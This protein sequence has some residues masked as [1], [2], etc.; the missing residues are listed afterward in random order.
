[1]VWSIFPYEN[2]FVTTTIEK[3]NGVPCLKFIPKNH[4][5][6]LPTIINYHGWHS[7]KEF[8]KFESMVIATNGYQVIVPDALHHGDRDAIDHDNPK[9]ID[10]YLWKIIFQGIKESK[11]FIELIIQDHN[12]EPDRIAVMGDSM[13]AII[14]SGVF[15]DNSDLKCLV[16]INGCAAW[17]ESIKNN[18]LPKNV[19][20]YDKLIE[21]YDPIKNK[22]RIKERPIL[23]LHGT[24]DTSLSINEQKLFFIKMSSLYQEDLEKFQF[25]EVDKINHRI[26]TGMLEKSIIWL[27]RYL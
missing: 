8:K 17:Q 7:S 9:N 12:A 6:L 5:G 21:Y 3:I 22:N 19:G 20:E 11:K 1:M 25:I 24:E 18:Y 2:N 16:Q 14:A 13:G 27:K 26:T 15:I 4:K 10:E 23:L